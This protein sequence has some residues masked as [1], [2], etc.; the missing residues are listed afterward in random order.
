MS[1][2]SGQDCWTSS[3]SLGDCLTGTLFTNLSYKDSNDSHCG[4]K[5][6]T[7]EDFPNAIKRAD[8]AGGNG[9]SVPKV[10]SVSSRGCL[11]APAILPTSRLGAR[12]WFLVHDVIMFTVI[13][14]TSFNYADVVWRIKFQTMS[15]TTPTTPLKSVRCAENGSCFFC[16]REEPNSRRRRSLG[17][18]QLIQKVTQELSRL[19]IGSNQAHRYACETPCYRDLEKFFKLKATI[20]TLKVSILKRFQEAEQRTKRCLPSDVTPQLSPGAKRQHLTTGVVKRLDFG[21]SVASQENCLS[22]NFSGNVEENAKALQV[23]RF[24]SP[25][26]IASVA[27][28]ISPGFLFR[29]NPV[30]NATEDL[31]IVKEESS[32]IQVGSIVNSE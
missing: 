2:N 27:N 3:R 31:N 15:E 8:T 10:G 18:N 20:E 25:W 19:S 13:S 29:Q 23:Q 21:P 16:G 6:H 9:T 26:P 32:G 7:G 28:L 30:L 4:R 5:A 14:E 22:V 24:L 17:Q 12:V 1:N 11:D